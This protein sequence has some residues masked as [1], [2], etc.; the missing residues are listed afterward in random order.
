MAATS[1]SSLEHSGTTCSE[2]NT[3]CCRDDHPSPINRLYEAT[4]DGGYL[5][6]AEAFY[7]T[8]RSSERFMNPNP[9]HFS[10]ENVIPAL[11]LLLYKVRVCCATIVGRW[12]EREQAGEGQKVSWQRGTHLYSVWG[13]RLVVY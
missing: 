2:N 5:T 3:H 12:Q 9:D 13:R 10:Y 4:G 7:D 1:P 6:D 8:S 11:H